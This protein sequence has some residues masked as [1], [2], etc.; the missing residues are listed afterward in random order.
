MFP[1]VGRCGRSAATALLANDVNCSLQSVA[2]V[3]PRANDS[4]SNDPNATSAV[5][6]NYNL[7]P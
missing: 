2:D 1:G 7:V 4:V 5:R 3:E 6:G